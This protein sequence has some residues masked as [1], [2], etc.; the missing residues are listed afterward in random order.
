MRPDIGLHWFCRG[1]HDSLLRDP[2]DRLLVH[3][4]SALYLYYKWTLIVWLASTL[5]QLFVA[6]L[7]QS[8]DQLAVFVFLEGHQSQP[9]LMGHLQRDLGLPLT[10]LFGYLANP[11]VAINPSS[12]VI[13]P[14][15]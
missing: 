6:R 1:K 13:M 5:G 7:R 11:S 4:P 3:V 10:F 12:F 14:L 15:G 2:I 8:A 9:V